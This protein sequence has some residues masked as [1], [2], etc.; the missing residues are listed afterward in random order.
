MELGRFDF[1]IPI[2]PYISRLEVNILYMGDGD[3]VGI[4]SRFI[5]FFCKVSILMIFVFHL[6]VQASPP[7]Q[8]IVWYHNVSKH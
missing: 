3:M 6:R 5:D 1:L 7:A 2:F 8:S 4:V